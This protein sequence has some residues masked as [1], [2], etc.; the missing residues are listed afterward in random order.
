MTYRKEKEM[1]KEW[2]PKELLCL[3]HLHLPY[4]SVSSLHASSPKYLWLCPFSLAAHITSY[5]DNC[6]DLLTGLHL[7]LKS[8]C[9]LY[10]LHVARR[11]FQK[12][13]SEHNNLG[14]KPLSGFCYPWG[15]DSKPSHDLPD[16]PLHGSDPTWTPLFLTLCF[17]I[18]I[19]AFVSCA[20]PH[21]QAWHAVWRRQPF[22]PIY[23]HVLKNEHIW[24]LAHKRCPM[25][26]RWI[27]VI[28]NTFG[29]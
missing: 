5:L 14:L 29:F 21:P 25:N 13:K 3:V 12:S 7:P 24:C 17:L 15:K 28:E 4:P 19:L 9:V 26:I 23:I 16:T 6:T 27:K 18:T 20:P 2:F 22:C 8:T 10:F 1:M 11:R